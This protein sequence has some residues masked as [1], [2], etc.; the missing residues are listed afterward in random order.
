MVVGEDGTPP[1]PDTLS[2][3]WAE[4]IAAHKLPAVRLHDARHTCATLM[5]QDGVPLAVISAWLGHTN[6]AFTLAT[7]GHSSDDSLAAAAQRL[8]ALTGGKSNPAEAK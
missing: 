1:H 6:A 4:T 2:H 7:Y 5:H 3:A 8:D